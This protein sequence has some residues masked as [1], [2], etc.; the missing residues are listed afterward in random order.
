MLSAI[1]VIRHGF[2]VFKL[3]AHEEFSDE[4]HF[5]SHYGV[6]AA[7]R[8]NEDE[9]DLWDVTLSYRF[10]TKDGEPK[11]R[12]EGE[13]VVEGVFSIRADFPEEKKESHACMNGGAVLLGA[14][15]EAVLNQTIRSINGP[16]ELPLVDARSFLPEEERVKP[17]LPE[18][19]AGTAN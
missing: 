9:R 11:G 1:Q 7:R 13:I 14:V 3:E 15:R 8:H 2:R 12:Y 18:K 5:V 10:G 4:S 16:V 17:L 19:K 6:E